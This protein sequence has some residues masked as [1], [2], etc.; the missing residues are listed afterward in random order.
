M[1]K[2]IDE[3]SFQW[4]A[5]SLAID[6]FVVAFTFDAL[7]RI[8]LWQFDSPNFSEGYFLFVSRVTENLSFSMYKPWFEM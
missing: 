8:T 6:W 1:F 5:D 3:K 4:W 2:V 7:A